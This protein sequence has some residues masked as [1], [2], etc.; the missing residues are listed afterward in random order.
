[1]SIEERI[2]RAGI[3][4]P[5]LD[6]PAAAYRPYVLHGGLLAISGQ[7][8]LHQAKPTATGAVP[9]M[10]SVAEAKHA[11]RQCAINVLA[12]ARHACQG[13]WDRIERVLRVGGYVV[14]SEGYFNAPEIINAASE[15]ITEVL[16]ERG[17]HARVAM[18][19]ASLP[20]NVSVE[21]EAMLAVRA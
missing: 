19:V 12:W 17:T 4:I 16:G 13:D 18:G 15:L 11:A 1:M 14:T 5:H 6:I 10:V 8:P 20:M 3:E 21:V 2:A 7:L 9:S